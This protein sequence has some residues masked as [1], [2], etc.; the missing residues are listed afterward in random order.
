MKR[1]APAADELFETYEE[2]DICFPWDEDGQREKIFEWSHYPSFFLPQTSSQVQTQPPTA[3]ST[4]QNVVAVA[5]AAAAVAKCMNQAPI[6]FKYLISDLDE[7]ANF[8]PN[9]HTEPLTQHF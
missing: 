1:K 3:C 9:R 2:K 8:S 4:T 5:N 6:I 7:A